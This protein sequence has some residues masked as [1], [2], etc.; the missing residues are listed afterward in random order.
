VKHIGYWLL[1]QHNV[2][3]HNMASSKTYVNYVNSR[4]QK[5]R[6]EISSIS[7]QESL[8]LSV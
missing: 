6:T 4:N 8:T 3:H 2:W 7:Y 1:A 5:D